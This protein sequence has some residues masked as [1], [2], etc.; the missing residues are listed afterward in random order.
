MTEMPV[1]YGT[2]P[3]AEVII[4]KAGVFAMCWLVIRRVDAGVASSP[5]TL[6]S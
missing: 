5:V 3:A 1:V 6:K 2:N 4:Y